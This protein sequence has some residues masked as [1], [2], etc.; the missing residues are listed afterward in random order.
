VAWLSIYD[1]SIEDGSSVVVTSHPANG[2][3]ERLLARPLIVA[4][5]PARFKPLICIRKISRPKMNLNCSALPNRR[6]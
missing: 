2:R 6:D 4:D 3:V 5:R 1:F